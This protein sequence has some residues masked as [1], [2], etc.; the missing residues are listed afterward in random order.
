MSRPNVLFLA[1]DSLRADVIHEERVPTPTIDALGE[2]GSVFRQCI[3]TTTT[4]TPSFASMLTG[5]YPPKHGIR[6]LQGYTLSP[7]LRTWPEVFAAAGY[8]THAEVTGPLLPATGVLRGFEEANHRQGYRVP[9]F[10][11]RDTVLDRMRSYDEPWFMLLHIWEVHRPFRSPPDFVK[12][13][14]RAGYEASVAASDERLAPVFEAAGDDTIVV[15]TGDH[16]ED[17]PDSKAGVRAIRATRQ[18]RKRL[19]PARW[20]PWLDRKFHALEVGHGFALYERLVRVPLVIAGPNVPAGTVTD[21]VRHVDLLPTIA[22]LCGIP[23]PEGLDGRSLRPLMEGRSLTEEPAYLEAV[24]VK[25]EGSRI[26]GA[27]TPQWKLLLP[28]AGRPALYS[29]DGGD[30]PNEKRNRYRDNPEVARRLRAFIEEI[31]RAGE[32]A[33]SGMSEAEEAVVEQHLRDLGYL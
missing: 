5:C 6:G 31:D 21:Q 17:F 28:G 25:L 16:G 30:R 19:K 15:F 7:T 3:S 8:S 23:A 20:L 27:R 32:S 22:D 18:I 9:F 12:R 26:L 10:G 29:L 13:F 4:T 11:W 33:R 14:D 2:R 1:V 24:G